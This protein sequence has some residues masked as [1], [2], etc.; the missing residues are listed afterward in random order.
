MFGSIIG[1]LVSGLLG[2]SD[3]KDTNEAN[4]AMSQEQMAF[5][6][7]MSSTAYQRA[8]KDMREAGLNPMLAYAQGGA[9]SPAGS[10]ATMSSPVAAGLSSAHQSAR[11][12]ADLDNLKETNKQ[13]KSQTEL[14]EANA[15]M[16]DALKTKANADAMLSANSAANAA[17]NN[18]LLKA[19][20]PAAANSAAVESSWVGKAGAYF[21]RVM[22]SLGRLN[23]F[24]SSAKN[25]QSLSRP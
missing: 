6:E 19:Q 23:P 14:N 25:I 22:D 8:T 3:Q 18:Q 16:A 15:K 5:Q 9:S 2:S 24:T 17:V 11:L 7:R 12:Y 13:I 10:T 1:G 4:R 20:V 21:D